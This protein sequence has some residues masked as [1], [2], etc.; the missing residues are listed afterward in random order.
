M[1]KLGKGKNTYYLVAEVVNMGGTVVDIKITDNESW[2]KSN[3]VIAKIKAE[4]EE[5]AKIYFKVRDMTR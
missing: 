4:S 2:A 1:I 5:E 3:T